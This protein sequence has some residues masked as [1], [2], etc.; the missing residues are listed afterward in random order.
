MFVSNIISTVTTFATNPAT[1]AVAKEFGKSV[2]KYVAIGAVTGSLTGALLDKISRLNDEY[3]HK[4]K[5]S[6]K[7]T[8]LE[9]T[10]GSCT[11]FDYYRTRTFGERLADGADRLGRSAYAMVKD[12]WVSILLYGGSQ[13]LKATPWGRTFTIG[14][15]AWEVGKVSWSVK[16]AKEARRAFR[17]SELRMEVFG[18]FSEFE[19]RDLAGTFRRMDN[20]ELDATMCGIQWGRRLA[21]KN[22]TDQDVKDM[23]DAAEQVLREEDVNNKSRKHFLSAARKAAV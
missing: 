5:V 22:L 19:E 13:A 15:V 1:Q 9:E 8:H 7:V 12:N 10:C 11:Y 4:E 14:L 23:L 3:D 21:D 18:I 6:E 20:D 16:N 17:T 2:A